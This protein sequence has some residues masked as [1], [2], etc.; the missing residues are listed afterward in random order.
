MGNNGKKRDYYDILGVEK[1]ATEQEIKKAYRKVAIKYHPDKNPD[2]KA[3]EEKFK[4]AAEAYEVLSD[5]QKRQRYDQF[6]HDGVKG[7]PGGFGG[8]GMNMED[9]FSQFGDIFGGGGGG[10]SSFF[11]GG[12]G[13]GRSRRG[14]NLRIR[15]SLSLEEIATG[16]EKKIKVNRLVAAEG[17]TFKTCETCGGRGQVT[18]VVNTMLGQMQSASTC[19]TCSGS[20]KVI[21]K[22]PSGVDSSGLESREEVVDIKIPAGVAD[23]MQLNMSGKGNEAPGG[24]MAGDLII[25]IGEKDHEFLQRDENNVLYDLHISFPDA[26]LGVEVEV[27]TLSGKAKIKIPSGTQGGKLLRLRGKGIP[28]VNGYGTGDQLIYVNV[29]TP[30]NL[31]KDEKKMLETLRES[32]HFQPNP[33]KTDKSFFDRIRE[34]I[35]G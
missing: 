27:P 20:G 31:S 13:G 18:R 33:K 15:L 21:D 32:D 3:A 5:A 22:R 17:V 4:E 29:W 2:D 6:G 8:G 9:I 35:F 14:S 25:L 10:F 19:P 7:G 12:G 24:G 1:G 26:A 28:S 23:G 30:K 34:G 11:G 16:V